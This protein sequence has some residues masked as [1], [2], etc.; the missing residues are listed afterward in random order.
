MSH[1]ERVAI[2]T[3]SA[4]GGL[5][6]AIARQLASEGALVVIADVD[7]EKAEM[8]L[9]DLVASGYRA[10]SIRVDV[11][12]ED[13]VRQMVALTRE[14]FGSLDI[15]VNNAGIISRR[16]IEECTLEEWQ[17]TFAVNVH[18]VFLCTKYSAAE[19]RRGGGGAIV[20]I[21]SSAGLVAAPNRPAYSATKGAIVA[22]TRQL[23]VDLAPWRIRVNS[24]APS[25]I[26]DTGMY[27]S[28]PDV[29]ADADAV[30]SELFRTH[31]LFAGHQR[32]A[33]RSDVARVVSFLASSESDMIT[34]VT[35]P[36]DG[37]F[38]SL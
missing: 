36:V 1:A 3:G 9:E 18:G 37:G 6:H 17:A 7:A 4:Y 30:K 34:G 14:T 38:T 11:T 33:S 8:T 25:S 10:K 20:N 27:Q 13:D 28:R 22:L 24:V 12:V 16:S 19:M 31:P 26:E 5:G 23:A 15:L 35:L 32:I 21:G 2:V 29:L